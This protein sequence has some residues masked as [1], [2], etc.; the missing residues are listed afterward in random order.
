MKPVRHEEIIKDL[1]STGVVKSGTER[2]SRIYALAR[3]GAEYAIYFTPIQETK[4]ENGKKRGTFLAEKRTINVELAV[5]N[6]NYK[7]QWVDPVTG[8]KEQSS[9]E[10]K[11]GR[12]TLRSP[13]FTQDIALSIR[14]P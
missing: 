12:L 11:N 4:E 10:S 8:R 2:T 3:E 6:G 5:P 14:R 9:A 7:A 13:E 1:S